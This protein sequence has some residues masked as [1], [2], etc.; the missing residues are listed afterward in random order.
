MPRLIDP[1]AGDAI[2]LDDLVDALDA[3]D[4]DMR[5]ED[6]FASVG[7]WL[8]RLGRNRDFLADLAI[9]SLKTRCADQAAENSYSAQVFLLRPGNGRYL[10]RANFWPAAGDAVVRAS[11]TA[12]FF[13]DMPHDHNFSFLTVGYLGPGYWSDYYEYDVAEVAGTVGENAGLHFVERSRL[14]TGKLMLYRARRDVHAQLPPDA[15]SVSLNILG[16][17]RAQP[18]WDQ[19]RFDLAA[20]TIAGGL[21]TTP[22]EALVALAA[23]FGGGNGT[24]LVQDF[25]TR[26]PSARMRFTALTALAATAPDADAR[27]AIFQAATGDADA[28]VAAQAR[29]RIALIERN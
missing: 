17:D 24:D 1:G 22:S 25:A 29:A 11:G 16:Y 4:F 12:P 10:L 6:S 9:D 13:Y 28:Y 8:A 14:E 7:P 15:F 20:G 3:H 27:H 21:T 5:S 2:G 18:W 19:Y 23:Q 26:H